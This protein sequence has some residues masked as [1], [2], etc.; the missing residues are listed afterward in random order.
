MA[1]AGGKHVV[2]RQDGKFVKTGGEKLTSFESQISQF[3]LDLEA[4]QDLK[5]SMQ[6]LFV[7][8]AKEM[9]V[10]EAGSITQLDT[11]VK[12]T[13]A[14]PKMTT[15]SKARIVKEAQESD[16]EIEETS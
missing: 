8:E 12:L 13:V 15:R 7:N 10:E 9:E 3:L 16:Q 5:G 1:A 14:T 11:S 4:N 2:A 6:E